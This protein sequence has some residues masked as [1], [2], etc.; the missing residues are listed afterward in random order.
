MK[1]LRLGDDFDPA[2]L[3]KYLIR[4]D[5]VLDLLE[6]VV[7][8]N[9]KFPEF[10]DVLIFSVDDIE[11]SLEFLVCR[12]VGQFPFHHRQG[13]MSLAEVSNLAFS[14]DCLPNSNGGCQGCQRMIK[15]N[16]PPIFFPTV[17]L[18][19]LS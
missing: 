4:L 11:Q 2:G 7:F 17:M 12:R 9:V 8:G 13:E 18:F 5:Q 1:L 14:L 15:A 10:F 16:P 6:V 3:H 19:I